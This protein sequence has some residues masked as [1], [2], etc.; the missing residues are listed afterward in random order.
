M[1]NKNY[2]NH[3]TLSRQSLN[4]HMRQKGIALVSSLL[5]LLAITLVGVT[6][7]RMNLSSEEMASNSYLR[8]QALQA[9][10]LG[11]EY[12]ETYLRAQPIAIANAVFKSGGATDNDFDNNNDGNNCL[13]GL[14]IPVNFI[15]G[16]NRLG[17][18][19]RNASGDV[20]S[21]ASTHIEVPA[22]IT[23]TFFP[24]GE[25]QPPFPPRFIIEFMG[26]TQGVEAK[27]QIAS[28]CDNSPQDGIISL[29]EG[30]SGYPFCLTD[31]RLFRITALGTAGAADNPVEVM[32]QS[33]F[34]TP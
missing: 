32:L 5:L 13:N 16:D 4:Q 11:L 34:I 6:S 1:N 19:V 15:A 22:A 14:C 33:T 25:P 9:A 27:E 26:H 18:W 8:D 20:W 12:G 23:G 21:T 30:R 31:P 17:Q 29:F 10:Q 28:V 7:L 3:T 24:A 2:M